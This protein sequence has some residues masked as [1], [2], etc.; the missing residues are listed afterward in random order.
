M[1]KLYVDQGRG[2]A[3]RYI[4][5]SAEQVLNKEGHGNVSVHCSSI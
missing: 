3:C 2:A 1:Q 4:N 5:S